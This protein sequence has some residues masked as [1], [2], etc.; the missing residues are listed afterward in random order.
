VPDDQDPVT[1]TYLVRARNAHAWTEVWF[2]DLGWVAFDPTADVPL[3]GADDAGATLGEW[4][5]DHLAL[6][7]LGLAALALLAGPVR[8]RWRRS[9]R[10]HTD[11]TTWAGTA[12]RRLGELG[13]R[14][15]RPRTPGETAST[16]AAALAHHLRAPSL[17][18][19][20]ATIDAALYAPEPPGPG[21]QEAADAVLA[22]LAD[23]EAPEPAP[24]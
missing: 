15:G 5:L 22:D 21:Q 16:F 19:V 24:A 11:P 13:A 7:V 14:V 3:A 9:V 12:D 2:P 4:V 8:G 18:A 23:A 6:I 17:A 20:G 1:G 10:G